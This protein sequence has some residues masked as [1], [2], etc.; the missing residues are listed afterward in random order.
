VTLAVLTLDGATVTVFE[1]A[2]P[3]SGFEAWKEKAVPFAIPKAC[4]V[5]DVAESTE[6]GI[7]LLPNISLVPLTKPEPV[8]LIT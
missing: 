4:P 6:T 5:S 3:G 8:M 1:V 2:A 7:A